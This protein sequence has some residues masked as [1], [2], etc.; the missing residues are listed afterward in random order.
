MP[1]LS[2]CTNPVERKAPVVTARAACERCMLKYHFRQ[3][4]CISSGALTSEA[5]LV[6]LP[7][8]FSSETI[9]LWTVFHVRSIS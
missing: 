9:M 1:H 3:T 7:S 8:W 4:L 6:P 5:E 2:L